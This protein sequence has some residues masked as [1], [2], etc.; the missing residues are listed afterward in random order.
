[1]D[2]KDKLETILQSNLAEDE[3]VL[4]RGKPD[5]KILF[6]D[7]TI[8]IVFPS[9]FFCLII[10]F[11]FQF[12]DKDHSMSLLFKFLIFLPP[13]IFD[14]IDQSHWFFR[15][16]NTLF[17][18]SNKHVF[19]IFMNDSY[20]TNDITIHKKVLS[21]IKK[22]EIRK[23]NLHMGEKRFR[24]FSSPIHYVNESLEDDFYF[25]SF[26]IIM[27]HMNY[28]TFFDLADVDTPATLIKQ[29]AINA[30]EYI[31]EINIQ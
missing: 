15:K 19:D 18:I 8:Q 12:F 5:M 7:E 22:Y 16:K 31:D 2:N 13:A 21:E 11:T 30:E 23:T 25:R 9:L 3:F 6:K 27:N 29:Y 26:N 10:F 14:I 1:M 20:N 17:V 28:F 24:I 4:W